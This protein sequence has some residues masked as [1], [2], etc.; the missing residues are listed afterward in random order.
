MS[1]LLQANALSQTFGGTTAVKHLNLSIREGRCV[2]LLGPNGAG[3]TTTIRML[4]GLL[5]PTGGSIHFQG[6]KAGEDIRRYIGYLPQTPSYYGWMS[7]E[8]LL[9]YAGQ[10]CGLSGRMA[11]T[12]AAELLQRV[13]LSDAARRRVGG[14]SGGMK[15]RLGIA[16]ALVH[17]P[18]LLILDEPVSA[19]D[20]I[21]RRDV[22]AL[23]TEL[24]EETTILFSTHVLHDAEAI[25]DDVVIMAAGRVAIAG[26]VEELRAAYRQ[27]IIELRF[28]EED[29]RSIRW[30]HDVLAG[31]KMIAGGASVTMQDGA[32]VIQGEDLDQLRRSVMQMIAEDDVKVS[33]IK[34]GYTSL[35]DLF[36]KAV[37]SGGSMDRLIP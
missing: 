9:I 29:D 27:P 16:Q 4:T 8:E 5:R 17:S 14:Y 12:R 10:L 11:K 37:G 3:K 26:T 35:E 19:L 33:Q 32:L 36:M 25:C 2:A 13:G 23:M 15:Q 28:E 24:K 6:E 21:G 30:S 20:P 34:A 7:G 22:L 31:S 1:A 18:K